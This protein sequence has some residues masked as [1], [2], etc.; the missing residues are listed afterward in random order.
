MY[1]SHHSKNI[2][3]PFISL[4]VKIII[5]IVLSVFPHADMD[6]K[7]KLLRKLVV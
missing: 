3:S 6:L 7:I 4:K 5:F 2:C 1:S